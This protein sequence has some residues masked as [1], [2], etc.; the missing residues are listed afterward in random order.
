MATPN[1]QRNRRVVLRW[2]ARTQMLEDFLKKKLERNINLKFKITT[3]VLADDLTLQ[4]C[5]AGDHGLCSVACTRSLSLHGGHNPE[6]Q[7][8]KH[9]SDGSCSPEL[10][11]ASCFPGSAIASS[12]LATRR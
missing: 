11:P 7:E 5:A 4:G 2:E 3:N 1:T 8:Q 6:Q 10:G 9:W 12:P